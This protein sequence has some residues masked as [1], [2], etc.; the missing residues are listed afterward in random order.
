[1]FWVTGV[2][3]GGSIPGT[4][5]GQTS[6]LSNWNVCNENKQTSKNRQARKTI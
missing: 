3:S 1:M 6:C 5:W 2:Y 4:Q